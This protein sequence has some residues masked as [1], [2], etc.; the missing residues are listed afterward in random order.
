MLDTSD[1]IRVRV[2]VLA[3]I[4]LFNSSICIADV[5]PKMP[6]EP[7]Q[8]PA[9]ISQSTAGLEPQSSSLRLMDTP[10][11]TTQDGI[12]PTSSAT[13]KPDASYTMQ[14]H[15]D[16][17]SRTLKA[18]QRISWRNTSSAP[19]SEVYLHLYWNA[20]K[21][22]NSLYFAEGGKK[23]FR[24]S[25]V[26]YDRDDWGWI[27]LTSFRQGD[28][29]LVTGLEFVQPDSDPDFV[30]M[31]SQ[32]APLLAPANADIGSAET[33]RTGSAQPSTPGTATPAAQPAEAS[34]AQ[35]GVAP[36]PA[37]MSLPDDETVVRI[38]LSSPVPPMGIAQF[39]TTFEA[40]IPKILARSGFVENYFLIGQWFPKLGVLNRD[41]ET[42]ET[43]ST[44]NC[45]SFHHRTEFYAD[46][47]TYDVSITLP[48]EYVV[49]ATG[50]RTNR[51]KN[52]DNTTTHQYQQA[53]VHDFA[54][55][56]WPEFIELKDRFEA[57]GLPPV[58][59]LLLCAP[60]DLASAQISFFA[61]KL[62]LR[63]F[64]ERFFP[65]PHPQIT[66]VMPPYNTE[67]S[68][69]MEYPTF[70]T[71]GRERSPGVSWGLWSVTVH[72][73]GHNYFQGLLASNEFEEAWLD[74]GF[75][76]YASNLTMDDAGLFLKIDLEPLPGWVMTLPFPDL[77]IR[78]ISRG[79]LTADHASPI[80]R[81]GWRYLDGA[82]YSMNS[83]GRTALVLTMLERYLGDDRMRKVMKTYAERFQFEHPTSKDFFQTAEAVAG[84][85]L[86]WFFDQF[87]RQNLELDYAVTELTR[88]RVEPGQGWHG[89]GSAKTFQ[90]EAQSSGFR[91]RDEDQ[92][93]ASDRWISTVTVRRLG[94]AYFPVTIR[95]TFQ[96]GTTQDTKWDGKEDW[97]RLTL[98][99]PSR[100]VHAEVDPDRILWMD[101]DWLN[102]GRI[103]EPDKSTLYRIQGLLLTASQWLLASLLSMV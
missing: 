44:W 34:R 23:S 1:L 9:S 30:R 46:F 33:P 2:P 49:G 10:L 25:A 19:I 98:E 65:F 101:Q 31:D 54:F 100:V 35:A 17:T 87:F 16:P 21:N 32:P 57:P 74:E 81:N 7:A 61:I 47:G 15:L 102:N 97:K 50:V 3:T 75:T 55:T 84:E 78:L 41:P 88:E 37:G 14:V 26:K 40:K 13:V 39:E 43:L 85:D 77:P 56:A 8:L 53:R 76:T 51:T 36:S 24:R 63:S 89:L 22:H 83:Y 86:D 94:S 71:T 62:A 66:I 12:L 103:F 69:G 27:E 80:M 73:F 28:A 18:T 82:D 58:D 90:E 52:A 67:E 60:E 91:R 93:T 45:H 29:E 72:E 95:V 38:P 68:A 20:F 99:G 4:F 70:I 64:G 48:S 42:G 5:P 59:I 79:M 96:D 6:Q 92:D 11:G